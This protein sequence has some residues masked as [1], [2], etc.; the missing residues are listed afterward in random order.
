MLVLGGGWPSLIP[1][2]EKH[3]LQPPGVA[4]DKSE[5]SVKGHPSDSIVTPLIAKSANDCA[6][7]YN[8]V[9]VVKRHC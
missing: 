8:R 5:G 1:G 6:T 2:F 4:L 3:I 7:L 9:G